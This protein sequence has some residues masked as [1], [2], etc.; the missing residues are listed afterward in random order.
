[1]KKLITFTLILISSICSS[2]RLQIN[3]NASK[4]ST[5][6][7]VTLPEN[8]ELKFYNNQELIKK[9]KFKGVKKFK[10]ENRNDYKL[11]WKNDKKRKIFMIY[12]NNDLEGF[13]TDR[14]IDFNETI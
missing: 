13:I 6:L 5:I 3:E 9:I 14:I 11:T 12:F 4:N 1:M 8:Y 10:I 7:K 2:Q